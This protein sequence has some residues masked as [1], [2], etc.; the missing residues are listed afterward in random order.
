VD[1]LGYYGELREYKDN[2]E[3]RFQALLFQEGLVAMSAVT[4][5]LAVGDKLETIWPGLALALVAGLVIGVYSGLTS[6]YFR[7]V[8]EVALLMARIERD[9]LGLGQEDGIKLRLTADPALSIFAR[10]RTPWSCKLYSITLI[11]VVLGIALVYPLFL[12]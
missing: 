7:Q 9:R 6:K 4:V 11:L 10:G 1:W 12:R 8:R 5:V 3:Q 2:L